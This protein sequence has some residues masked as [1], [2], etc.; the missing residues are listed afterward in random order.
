[1]KD[2]QFQ[3]DDPSTTSTIE[4]YEKPRFSVVPLA[5]ITLGGTGGEDD[6]GSVDIQQPPEITGSRGWD[7]DEDDPIGDPWT[8]SR[9]GGG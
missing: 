3:S 8:G 1:M 9:G 6:S 5:L 7:E 2:E 4:T